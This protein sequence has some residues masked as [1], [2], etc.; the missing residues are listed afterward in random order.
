MHISRST[1]VGLFAGGAQRTAAVTQQSFNVNPSSAETD[2]GC[3]A[4][5]ARHN[6]ANNQSPERS[7]VNIRPVLFA[8]CAAGASPSTTNRAEGSPNAGT[9]RPQYC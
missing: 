3:D 2:E 5:P 8:P 7:P 9:G 6:A 1:G 4:Y